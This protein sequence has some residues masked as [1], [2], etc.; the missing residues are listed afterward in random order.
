[1]LALDLQQFPA[2]REYG[3]ARAMPQQDVH[4]RSCGVDDM[5]T[6]IEHQKK[7]LL[8]DGTCHD[9]GANVTST[10]PELKHLGHRGRYKSGIGQRRQLDYPHAI[11]E[12]AEK[13]V[14]DFNSERGL[15]DA[16][17]SGES[18]GAMSPKHFSRLPHGCR[19][20]DQDRVG[21]GQIG[22]GRLV[23]NPDVLPADGWPRRV[24]MPDGPTAM[25]AGPVVHYA[26]IGAGCF[27]GCHRVDLKVA[28]W[29]RSHCHC[30]RSEAI[31]VERHPDRLSAIASLR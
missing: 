27:A 9:L 26:P 19:S 29:S 8:V 20:A 13:T 6:A 24:I 2:G 30:E 11:F 7:M 14:G 5:L 23:A 17:G 18:H 4:E 16:A 12:L 22:P 28:I 15:P 25:Q 3:D 10:R 1:M 31:W 21:G